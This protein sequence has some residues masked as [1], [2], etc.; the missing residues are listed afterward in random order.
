MLDNVALNVVIGL[1]FIYLLYSLFATVLSEII[2]TKLGL[3][4]RNL[5]EAVDRMLNDGEDNKKFWDY[6]CGIQNQKSSFFDRS[7]K[8]LFNNMVKLSPEKRMTIRQVKQSKWYKGSVYTPQELQEK[9]AK[10]LNC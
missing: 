4:A 6:H 5:K 10:I 2:A 7:F 8:E 3:R 9:M 1:V